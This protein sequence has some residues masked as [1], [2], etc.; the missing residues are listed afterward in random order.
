MNLDWTISG[1]SV[2][3]L[4]AGGW[5]RLWP[6]HR[7]ASPRPAQPLKSHFESYKEERRDG[8]RK[9]IANFWNHTNRLA[10]SAAPVGPAP[11]S[12]SPHRGD[13]KGCVAQQHSAEVGCTESG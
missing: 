2:D 8:C 10:G 12:K 1:Q 11:R 13:K 3:G 9:S 5:R 7:P 6:G 4:G